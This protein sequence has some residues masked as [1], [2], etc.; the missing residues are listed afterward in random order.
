[1]QMSEDKMTFNCMCCKKNF[2]PDPSM[3]VESN[4]LDESGFPVVVFLCAT[5][6]KAIENSSNEEDYDT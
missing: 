5:C 2:D 6:L 1:M 4:T 3:V